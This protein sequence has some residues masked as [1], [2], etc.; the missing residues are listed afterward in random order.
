M[1][2]RIIDSLSGI[3]FVEPCNMRVFFKRMPKNPET[4]LKRIWNGRDTSPDQQHSRKSDDT[5]IVTTRPVVPVSYCTVLVVPHASEA[6]NQSTRAPTMTD[7][8]AP[9]GISSE[10]ISTLV[11]IIGVCFFCFGGYCFRRTDPAE[12]PANDPIAGWI[13]VSLGGNTDGAAANP[14]LV[15]RRQQIEDTLIIRKVV[16]MQ[17]K[18]IRPGLEQQQQSSGKGSWVSTRSLGGY[19]AAFATRKSTSVRSLQFSDPIPRQQ[20][21]YRRSHSLPF[22]ANVENS[23]GNGD[24]E[25]PETTSSTG[26]GT[27]TTASA[28]V[29]GRTA[30]KP[31]EVIPGD[32]Q[33]GDDDEEED[34]TRSTRIRRRKTDI[35]Q[36]R[37][38]STLRKQSQDYEQPTTCDIC[39]MDYEVGEEVAWS[40]NDAC[41][42]AFHKDCIVDWLLRNENCPLCR[43][44]YLH[45]SANGSNT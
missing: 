22:A 3:M 43:N 35:V 19:M 9:S 38:A 33:E 6:I 10:G 26:A 11:T 31:M 32:E 40:P 13:P 18:S 24:T 7:S 42:H 4:L 8:V 41:V 36:R 16:E 23:G 1:S 25:N 20:G 5:R 44:D 15:E 39:L 28:V 17:D 14:T 34:V 27:T 21:Q 45:V 30:T 12:D 2:W 37:L 29:E